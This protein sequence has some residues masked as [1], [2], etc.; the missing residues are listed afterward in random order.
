MKIRI[1][2]KKHKYIYTYV[3]NLTYQCEKGSDWKVA[4]EVLWLMKAPG[5]LWYAFDAPEDPI[6]TSID[7]AKVRFV[8]T[9][10]NANDPGWHTWTMTMT[11]NNATGSFETTVLDP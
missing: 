6:P 1:G 9:G 8:S 4:G 5:G 11:Q 2:P 3:G 10:P 7:D